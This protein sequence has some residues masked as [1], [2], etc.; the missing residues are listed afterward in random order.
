MSS[1]SGKSHR[2]PEVVCPSISFSPISFLE[3]GYGCRLAYCSISLSLRCGFLFMKQ[4]VGV[5]V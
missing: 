1:I 3:E 2:T 4:E 5:I